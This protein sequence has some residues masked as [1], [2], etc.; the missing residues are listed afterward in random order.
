MKQVKR[1]KNI[2]RSKIP[3]EGLSSIR[4]DTLGAL[5]KDRAAQQVRIVGTATKEI[6]NI[7]KRAALRKLKESK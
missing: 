4:R 5:Q 1:S 3:S 7:V 6:G 2:H